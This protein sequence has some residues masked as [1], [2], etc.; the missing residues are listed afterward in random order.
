[1]LEEPHDSSRLMRKPSQQQNTASS[2]EQNFNISTSWRFIDRLTEEQSCAC[3][4]R[5]KYANKTCL[6]KSGFDDIF[7]KS[8]FCTHR[9]FCFWFLSNAATAQDFFSINYKASSAS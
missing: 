4:M 7:G 8:S 1:V 5:M 2:R 9:H 6:L 3:K